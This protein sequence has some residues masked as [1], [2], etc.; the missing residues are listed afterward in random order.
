[1]PNYNKICKVCNESFVSRRYD[2]LN[3]SSYCSVKWQYLKKKKEKKEKIKPRDCIWCGTNFL[4][5]KQSKITCSQKCYAGYKYNLKKGNFDKFDL[6]KTKVCVAC[7]K[8]KKLS[9]FERVRKSFSPLCK[10]CMHIHNDKKISKLK[11]DKD[12]STYFEI[13]EFVNKVKSKAY[14]ADQSDIFK[15]IALYDEL[16]PTTTIPEYPD[17][18]YTFNIIFAKVLDWYKLEKKSILKSEAK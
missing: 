18:E 7:E 5:N 12:K 3:C 13:D 4:P 17:S 16:Y 1:M 6:D 2:V 14:Y 11:S 9:H 8:E 15:L 10:D